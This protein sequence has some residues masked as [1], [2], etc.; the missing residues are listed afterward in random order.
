VH[1]PTNGQWA[2]HS[3][4][5]NDPRY[6]LDQPW[7]HG[8]FTGGIGN[9]WQLS[10]GG[11]G[12]FWFAGFYFDVAPSDVGLCAAWLWDSDQI[13]IYEDPRHVGWYLSYNVRLGTY[14]HVMYL[15]GS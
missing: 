10:G 14:C 8:R 7:E 1:V 5:P 11:P 4:D 13:V 15:A 6:R 2:G 3:S 9:V 12:R